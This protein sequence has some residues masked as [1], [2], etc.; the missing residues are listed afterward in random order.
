[1]NREEFI[2]KQIEY[3]KKREADHFDKIIRED[4]AYKKELIKLYDRTGK[5]MLTTVESLYTRYALSEGIPI[6]EVK[7]RVSRMDADAFAEKAKQYVEEKNFSEE[8]N[9]QLKLYN[10]KIQV[11]RLQ[12]MEHE[13]RLKTIE[14]ADEE[15]RMLEEKLYKAYEEEVERQS[16]I[17]NLTKET[18]GQVLK[19]ADRVINGDF[20]SAR[21][22]DRIWS[23]QQELQ[24]KLEKGLTRSLLRGENP[25]IWAREIKSLVK[26]N[27]GNTGKGN[28]LYNANRIA[29]TETS[30]VMNEA[31]LSVFKEAGYDSYIWV[32]EPGACHICAPYHDEV[33]KVV[34]GRIGDTLPPMHPFCRCSTAAYYDYDPDKDIDTNWLDIAKWFL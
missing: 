13:M 11:S 27:M 17:L 5:D 12:L 29:I 21:F 22:S 25:K 33:F 19:R 31:R 18:R 30:R 26:E 4:E 28:A 34:D 32:C 2:K 9:Q 1:M 23:N 7:K 24:S 20:H 14:L 3:T 6:E 8:A 15:A 10:L 16:T